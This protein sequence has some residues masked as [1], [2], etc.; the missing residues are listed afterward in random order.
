M[1]LLKEQP[2]TIFS[3]SDV[4]IYFLLGYMHY[5][6]IHLN[7]PQ[8]ELISFT[9][10]THANLIPPPCHLRQ[11]PRRFLNIFMMIPSVHFSKHSQFKPLAKYC[12]W[13]GTVVEFSVI[14]LLPVLFFSNPSPTGT[15]EGFSRNPT[16]LTRLLI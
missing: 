13:I 6:Q 12:L 2:L 14:S 7:V 9:Q 16:C 4:Y 11:N 10:T 3:H 1:F 15:P 8:T 5:G